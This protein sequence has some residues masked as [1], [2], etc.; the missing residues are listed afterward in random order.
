MKVGGRFFRKI[1]LEDGGGV[2]EGN[3]REFI[4]IFEGK[5]IV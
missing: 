5:L 1:L 2:G 3:E 4:K